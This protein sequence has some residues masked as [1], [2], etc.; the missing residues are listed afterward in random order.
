MVFTGAQT[1]LFFEHASQMGLSNRMRMALDAEGVVHVED[2]AEWRSDEWDQFVENC[3]WAPQLPDPA[4]AGALI[5]QASFVIPVR[6]LKHLKIAGSIVHYYNSVG[7]ELSASNM[8]W[9][10]V[11]SNFE[12]QQRP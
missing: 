11:I 7:R 6:S 5:V 10:S 4:N 3:K 12:I 1:S 9:S 2:L 8:Q